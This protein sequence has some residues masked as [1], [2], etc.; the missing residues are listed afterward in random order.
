VGVL[1]VG[2]I[3]LTAF[4]LSANN[5][6]KIDG[7]QISFGTVDFQ[8][9]P[10]TF[11]LVFASLD[12]EMDLMFGSLN[13]CVGSLGSIRLSD[14]TKSGLSA[15]KTAITAMSESSVDSSS[16]VNSHVSFTM[17]E[18]IEDTIEELDEIMRNLDLGE[19]SDHSGS[20]QNFGRSISADFTTRNVGVSNNVHQVCVI[21]TKAAEDDDGVDNM[22]V[23][24][25]GGN[26]KNSHRKEKEKVYVSAGGSKGSDTFKILG[27]TFIRSNSKC[28]KTFVETIILFK[29]LPSKTPTL[30]K[31]EEI[32]EEEKN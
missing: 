3:N 24:A 18:N 20:N 30:F 19:A 22:V 32:C 12:Q 4:S 14:P 10:P 7:N 17:I 16:E 13:F 21:I 1:G 11:T 9:H 25:Q 15:G 8:P 2:I 31:L 23:N 29:L 26:P 6:S 5:N 28:L 27:I